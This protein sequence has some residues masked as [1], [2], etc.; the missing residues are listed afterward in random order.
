MESYNS[1]SKTFA[2][3]YVVLQ[4]YLYDTDPLALQITKAIF[5]S[6]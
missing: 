3:I 6:I 1:F 2:M 5:N 4:K